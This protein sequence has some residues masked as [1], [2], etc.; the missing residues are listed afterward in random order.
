[1][2][3]VCSCAAV[4]LPPARLPS[5]PLP[6]APTIQP[7]HSLVGQRQVGLCDAAVNCCCNGRLH[8][9]PDALYG[10][11]GTANAN[12]TYC[13][14]SWDRVG[15]PKWL[16][17]VQGL[18]LLPGSVAGAAATAA[19]YTH[20]RRGCC[21]CCRPVGCAECLPDVLLCCDPCLLHRQAG[22][23]ATGLHSGSPHHSLDS[24]VSAAGFE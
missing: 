23:L 6:T 22:C 4:L 20:S 18:L 12:N 14:V 7:H 11:H 5:Q 3:H 16:Q 8:L 9:W 17:L 13:K 10:L 15:R 1:M 24:H 21:G 19:G 2:F